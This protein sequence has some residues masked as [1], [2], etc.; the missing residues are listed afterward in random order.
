MSKTVKCQRC[1]PGPCAYSRGPGVNFTTCLVLKRE[2][3]SDARLEFEGE[4]PV[5]FEESP[6]KYTGPVGG[7]GMSTS[8]ARM[9]LRQEV[10]FK[11]GHSYELFIA[12]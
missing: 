4:V 5:T 8:P 7:M 12:C 3:A 11:G 2:V 9:L 10:S 1:G 6:G